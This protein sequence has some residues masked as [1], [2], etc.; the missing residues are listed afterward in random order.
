MEQLMLRTK[1]VNRQNQINALEQERQYCNY[2]HNSP[3]LKLQL[4][5]QIT[6]IT[7]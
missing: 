3:A 6:R 7:T 5:L 4:E 1:L 2:V